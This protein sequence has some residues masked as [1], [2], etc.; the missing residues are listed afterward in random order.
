MIDPSLVAFRYEC[1]VCH[2]MHTAFAHEFNGYVAESMRH[3]END[4]ARVLPVCSDCFTNH[5]AQY[6]TDSTQSPVP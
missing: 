2:R 1:A 3:I 6:E 4:E 5:L